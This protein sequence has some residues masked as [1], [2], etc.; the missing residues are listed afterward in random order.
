MN[1]YN[2]AYNIQAFIFLLLMA[3]QNMLQVITRPLYIC[4]KMEAR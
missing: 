1:M 2:R 4:V 3:L